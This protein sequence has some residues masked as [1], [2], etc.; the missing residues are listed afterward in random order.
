M[1][2]A[3]TVLREVPSG[4]LVTLAEV[5][6]APQADTPAK[7]RLRRLPNP[8]ML[9]TVKIPSSSIAR[10]KRSSELASPPLPAPS[11]ARKSSLKAML[12]TSMR[13]VS[14]AWTFVKRHAFKLK[15]SK[16]MLARMD[17]LASLC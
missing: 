14:S 16:T 5:A 10:R 13:A 12:G 6:V 15:M 11:E 17:L 3:A 7:T 9:F 2:T 1:A 8:G 4:K